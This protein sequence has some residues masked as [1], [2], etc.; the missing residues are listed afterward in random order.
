M[1]KVVLKLVV[2]MQNGKKRFIN[3]M[4][5]KPWYLNKASV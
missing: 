1:R 4:K 2:L 5:N 3:D